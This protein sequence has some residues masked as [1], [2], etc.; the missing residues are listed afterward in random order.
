MWVGETGAT[1]TKQDDDSNG[2]GNQNSVVGALD[3]VI[4]NGLSHEVG[5]NFT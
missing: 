4:D 3:E 2:L 1:N 5:L